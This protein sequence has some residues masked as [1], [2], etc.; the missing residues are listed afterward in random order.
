MNKKSIII[1]VVIVVLLI[2]ISGAVETNKPESSGEYFTFTDSE[3]EIVELSHKPQKT[4]VLFSSLAEC[5][6]EAG[7][8]V[9]VT[10]GE[11]VERGLV[12]EETELVD[13]GA[14]KTVDTEKLISLEPDFVICSADIASHRDVA[15]ALKKA[16]IPVAMLRM[17]TFEDYLTILRTLT[18]ITGKTENYEQFGENAKSE[19]E[20][21]ISGG[22][23][24]NNPKILF[25]RSG[26]SYSSAKAK[27]ADDNF[28][29]KILEDFGCINIADKAEVLLDN[30]SAE[31]IL[32]ENPQYIFVSVMGDYDN[33]KAYMQE[34]LAKKEYASLDAVKNGR[35]YFLPKELFQYKP[36]GRWA[37]SYRYIS[38]ILNNE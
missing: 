28:A 17:D 27:K 2:F 5:W 32:K 23:R 13:K 19:I 35:V 10:V 12:K 9:Y 37:E 20:Q 18:K 6:I 31:V 16:K 24:E 21:I 38:S 14:G 1:A 3:G 36:C 30:L 22:K 11:S 26:S 29:A 34:L 8:E 7:G 4:A 33:S 25:V 15:S